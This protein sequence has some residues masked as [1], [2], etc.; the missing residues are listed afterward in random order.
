MFS[1]EWGEGEGEKGGMEGEGEKVG[2]EAERGRGRGNGWQGGGVVHT[3]L[4]EKCFTQHIM[5]VI[6]FIKSK[7]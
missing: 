7:K 3:L 2:G 4:V 5:D 6:V 1:S